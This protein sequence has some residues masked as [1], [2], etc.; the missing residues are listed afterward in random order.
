M[1][2]CDCIV[3]QTVAIKVGNQKGGRKR[4]EL[5]AAAGGIARIETDVVKRA[6]PLR[7]HCLNLHR[8]QLWV[9]ALQAH[10]VQCS[11]SVDVCRHHRLRENTLDY[12]RKTERTAPIAPEHS[13]VE[14]KNA[15]RHHDSQV[16]SSIA[17]DIRRR[18]SAKPYWQAG[19]LWTPKC[20]ITFTEQQ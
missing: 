4:G 16:K 6:A 11:V 20:S 2:I 8:Y 18:K 15:F 7:S 3:G 14:S 1:Q 5:N 13:N 12:W 17:I 10:K 9:E 19:N